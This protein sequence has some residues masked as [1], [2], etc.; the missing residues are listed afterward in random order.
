MTASCHW[1]GLR[2]P[3]MCRSC[4]IQPLECICIA[5]SDMDPSIRHSLRLEAATMSV[6][7]ATAL[8]HPNM[9]CCRY[10][11]VDKRISISTTSVTTRLH[12]ATTALWLNCLASAGLHCKGI[13]YWFDTPLSLSYTLLLRAIEAMGMFMYRIV[14]LSMEC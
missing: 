10:I 3:R 8:R 6:V 12:Y 4:L 1:Y 2:P 13:H 5:T 7:A 11:H 14:N 9:P